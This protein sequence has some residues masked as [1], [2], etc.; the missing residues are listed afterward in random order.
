[1]KIFPQAISSS[2]SI[3]PGQVQH[4]CKSRDKINT[5]YDIF[6][7]K[8]RVFSLLEGL[9]KQQH[10][11]STADKMKRAVS[12]SISCSKNWVPIPAGPFFSSTDDSKQ[13]TIQRFLLS[14]S[15]GELN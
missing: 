12:S 15:L 2:K 7:G 14:S 13:Q 3:F 8:L 6:Y 4:V 9:S 5:L 10:V 1:M 11:R